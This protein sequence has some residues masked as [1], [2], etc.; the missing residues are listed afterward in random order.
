MANILEVNQ[1]TKTIGKR[2]IIDETSF[3][4]EEGK[5]YG[6]IGPNGAGKTTLMRIMTGLIKPTSGEVRI[7]SYNVQTQRQQA[8]S[9]VGGIIESPIFFEYMT[10]RQV[11]RNLSRLHPTIKSSQREEQIEKLL[12]TVGLEKR[13]EDK[14]RTYSL[15]MKQRLG[16]AQSM[17]GGPKLLLLDE[18]SNGLDPIGMRELR[19]IIFKLRET[20]N[21]A[22]FISSH[23][24]DELQQLCDELI[25]IREGT[26]IWKGLTENIVKDGQRLEDAFMELVQ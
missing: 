2:V 4:L 14:V 24:L 21:L 3:Q 10:G 23:L 25:V 11:L 26:I 12:T 19:D 17:L 6:F 1:I 22:F 13:G 15:G 5:I 20:E 8:I 18:P 9:R 7:D 16:I